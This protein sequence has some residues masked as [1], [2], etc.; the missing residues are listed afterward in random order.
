MKYYPED[1]MDALSKSAASITICATLARIYFE[2]DDEVIK[3]DCREAIYRAKRMG[4][5]IKVLKKEKSKMEGTLK[6][7]YKEM[8]K[9]KQWKRNLQKKE[10]EST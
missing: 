3:F 4:H 2:T 10:S 6:Y 8:E 9:R 1:K 5:A 7:I